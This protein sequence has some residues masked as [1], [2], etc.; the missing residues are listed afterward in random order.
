MYQVSFDASTKL[1]LD[2]ASFYKILRIVLIAGLHSDTV[3]KEIQN[4][5]YDHSSLIRIRFLVGRMNCIADNR[6]KML[7]KAAGLKSEADPKHQLQKNEVRVDEQEKAG[8][9]TT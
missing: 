9:P 5:P 2:V 7:G 8:K 6:Q 1:G 4:V 3:I